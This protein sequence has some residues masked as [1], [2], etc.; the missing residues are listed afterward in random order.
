MCVYGRQ[1]RGVGEGFRFIGVGERWREEEVRVRG[2]GGR[3]DGQWG[4]GTRYVSKPAT[5]FHLKVHIY[6]ITC[7][8]RYFLLTTESIDR[9]NPDESEH[10]MTRLLFAYCLF[11]MG[12][13]VIT[14][15]YWCHIIQ[16]ILTQ[17]SQE[18]HTLYTQWRL[19]NMKVLSRS[20][21]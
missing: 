13:S 5:F 14:S 17:I 20:S 3:E 6:N 12:K 10:K 1:R 19:T 8:T 16:I 9:S 15:K 18:P 11:T 4:E 21:K 2:N 7:V